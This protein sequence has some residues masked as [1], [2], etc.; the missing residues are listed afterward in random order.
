MSQITLYYANWCGHCQQFKPEWSKVVQKARKNG[1]KTAEYEHGKNPDKIKEAD[2]RGFPTIRIAKG[3]SSFDYDG[4]RIADKII[5]VALSG[6]TGGASHV[7]Y[8]GKSDDY[9]KMKYLK[10]KAKYLK[11]Q[12]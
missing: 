11:L 12:I 5:E 3:G 7:M 2:I 6:Q 10:Y 9:Y 4:E 1:I 8:G